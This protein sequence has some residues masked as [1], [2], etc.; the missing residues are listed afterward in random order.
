MDLVKII[1]HPRIGAMLHPQYV[2]LQLLAPMMTE[3]TIGS[4]TVTTESNM[5]ECTESR[6]QSP[7]I[8]KTLCANAELTGGGNATGYCKSVVAE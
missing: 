2:D 8:L 1:S 3:G 4:P 7:L 5:F 6:Y